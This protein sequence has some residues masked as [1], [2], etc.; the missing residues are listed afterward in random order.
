MAMNSIVLVGFMGAGKTV[1]GRRLAE[2]LDMVFV[3][4]DE[5]IEEKL[6]MSVNE[7]FERFGEHFFRE[8]ERDVVSEISNRDRLV[9]ATGGGIVLDSRNVE[10]LKDLGCLIHLFARPDVILDRTKDSH[11]RPLLET[12]DREVRIERLLNER[13]PFYAKAHYEIDTSDLDVEDIAE[14]IICYLQESSYGP[15]M[16]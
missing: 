12:R 10:N 9:V 8:V 11:R 4:L 7:I 1:V 13:K 6:K 14:K 2:L 5:L 16:G 3:D 15:G